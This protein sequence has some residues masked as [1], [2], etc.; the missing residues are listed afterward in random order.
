MVTAQRK[1]IIV[2]RP[3]TMAA[4]HLQMLLWIAPI[5]KFVAT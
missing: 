2:G 1:Q 3:P 5:T 4:L